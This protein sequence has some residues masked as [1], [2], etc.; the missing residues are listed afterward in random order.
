VL[1]SL[2]DIRAAYRFDR[3]VVLN[4]G[5]LEVDGPPHDVLTA[6]LIRRVFCVEARFMNSLVPELP[7]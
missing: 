7:V 2:H 1:V 6:E 5:R 3:V 4:Q